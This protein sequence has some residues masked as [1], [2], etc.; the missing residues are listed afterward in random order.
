MTTRQMER[1]TW[2]EIGKAAERDVPVLIPCGTQEA[3]GL[4]SPMGHDSIVA[5]RLALAVS[6]RVECLVA[7]TVPFG[8]S[9]FLTPFPGTITLRSQTMEYLFTDI[10]ESLVKHGFRHLIFINNHGASEPMLWHVADEMRVKHGVVIAS[11][12][13][14]KLAQDLSKD[15]FETQAGVFAHGGEP[16]ISVLLYLCPEDMKL[17]N[18]QRI[19]FTSPWRGLEVPAPY[20]V[21]LN[22]T[23]VTVYMD[24]AEIAPTG[25][26]GDPAQGS[27]EKGRIMFERMVEFIADFVTKYRVVK[28]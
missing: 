27:A 26:S 4:Y 3:Q 15:L 20:T 10:V 19:P 7:P 14:S 28:M 11:I 13:P 2:Q 22:G 24:M 23:N 5:E 21:R 1:M 17:D 12:F 16:T 25:G 8:Y 9:H 6:E 18:P